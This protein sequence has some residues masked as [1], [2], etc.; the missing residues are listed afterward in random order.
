VMLCS[1]TCDLPIDAV[2]VLCRSVVF[3][4]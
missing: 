3:G 2:P 1:S 4:A